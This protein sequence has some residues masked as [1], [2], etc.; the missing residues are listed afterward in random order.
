MCLPGTREERRAHLNL[1]K[2]CIERGGHSTMFRGLLADYLGT[3]I[4][5]SKKVVLCH[6][7]HNSDCSNPVHMYWGT[8][9]DN[10]QDQ[11]D[12][13]TFE[14]VWERSVKKYGLAEAKRRNA[15]NSDKAAAGRGNR[16]KPKSEEHKRKI[17]EAIKRKHRQ[18]GNGEIGETQQT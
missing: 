4:Y 7:C 6:G 18:R 10:I 2:K 12:N 9:D 1:R 16:G 3:E 5:I 13:G 14:S 17:A 8:Y 11:K 15:R